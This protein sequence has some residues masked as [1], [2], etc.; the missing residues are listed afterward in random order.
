MQISNKPRGP[1]VITLHRKATTDFGY[2]CVFAYLSIHWPSN[3]RRPSVVCQG[4]A[5]SVVTVMDAVAVRA[6][7][8][9]YDSHVTEMPQQQPLIKLDVIRGWWTPFSLFFSL[10]LKSCLKNWKNILLGCWKYF[11][12]LTCLTFFFFFLQESFFLIVFF[13]FR[14]LKVFF[15]PDRQYF[16][17]TCYMFIFLHLINDQLCLTSLK[18]MCQC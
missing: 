9:I 2:Y 12:Y 16:P 13:L 7:S 1:E 5:L 8:C 4:I 10:F 18:V 11:L 15:V 17:P 14:F 6:Q 3:F